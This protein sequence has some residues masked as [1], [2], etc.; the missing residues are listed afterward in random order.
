[1]VMTYHVVYD[2]CPMVAE[3]THGLKYVHLLV[4]F[5]TLPDTADGDVQS[6]LTDS[7]AAAHIQ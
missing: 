2:L 7:V 6:A 3:F 4:V 5:K 1:M